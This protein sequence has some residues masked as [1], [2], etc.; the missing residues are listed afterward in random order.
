MRTG[1][2][3]I[4]NVNTTRGKLQKYNVNTRRE[5]GPVIFIFYEDEREGLWF[6]RL[7]KRIFRSSKVFGL[8]FFESQSPI[9]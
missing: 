6:T 5:K 9:L 7:R 8:E 1:T 2:L 3:K 4:Y